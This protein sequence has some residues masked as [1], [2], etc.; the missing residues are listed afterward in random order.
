MPARIIVLGLGNLLYADE[1]LGV[2]VAEHLYTNYDFPAHVEIVDGGTQ[3]ITLLAHV[4]AADRLLILDAVDFGLEPGTVVIKES[5]HIPAYITAHKASV[6]QNSF[7]EVLGL[8]ELTGVL[9]KDIVL[10]GMQ[11]V[12]LAFGDS[13][14]D[15]AKARLPELAQLALDTLERWDVIPSPS[16]ATR[17]FNDPSLSLAAF[18]A[19]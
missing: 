13:L 19:V 9:P 16:R 4:E 14:S 7:S 10:I 8:A 2:R 17:H 3:G 18:E 5:G 6:H 12:S 1:G 15:E 11:P